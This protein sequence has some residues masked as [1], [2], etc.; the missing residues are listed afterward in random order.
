MNDQLVDPRGGM[1]LPKFERNLSSNWLRKTVGVRVSRLELSVDVDLE[2]GGA[3]RAVVSDEHVTPGAGD[4]MMARNHLERIIRPPVNQVSG[5]A[6]VF[7]PDIP[8]AIVL[9]IVHPRQDRSDH[10]RLRHLDPGS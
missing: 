1:A 7:E 2:S 3:A 4:H 6:S 10:V 5:H 8:S 9:A